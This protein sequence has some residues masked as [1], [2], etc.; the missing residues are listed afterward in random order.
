MQTTKTERALKGVK[1]GE[2]AVTIVLPGIPP[3]TFF[4]LT[5][6]GSILEKL[7]PFFES[8]KVKPILDPL[9]PVPFSQVIHALSFIQTAR[10][11]G[12]VV[13]YPIP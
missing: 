12:K 11:T 6:K 10:A 13:V 5:S 2:K 8:G 4:S 1:E 7:R 3:A 9:T